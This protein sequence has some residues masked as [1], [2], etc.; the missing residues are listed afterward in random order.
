MRYIT[1]YPSDL[2][3]TYSNATSLTQNDKYANNF[4]NYTYTLELKDIFGNP[5]Y[6]KQV[7]LIDQ[8]SSYY[9]TG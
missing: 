7:N 9:F 3:N 6:N 2:H 8:D 1:I 5:I 4:D